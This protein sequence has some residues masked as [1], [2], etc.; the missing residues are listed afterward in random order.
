MPE[1]P[2]IEAPAAPQAPPTTPQ[3]SAPAPTAIPTTPA[4]TP[5]V[6]AGKFKSIEDL[7]KGY[8]E[9]QKH[10][11]STRP[12]PKPEMMQIE[13][14]PDAIEDADIPTLIE[15]AGLK[16]D[17][18]EGHWKEHGRLTDEQYAAIRKKAPGM[19]N[20]LINDMAEGLVA[21]TELMQVRRQQIRSECAQILGGE[22]QLKSLL[23]AASTF[24]PPDELPA[25][26]RLLADPKTAK[27]AIRVLQQMH[28]DSV[29]A[30]KSKPLIGGSTMPGGGPARSM[31]EYNALIAAVARG[32]QGARARIMATSPDDIEKW[33]NQQ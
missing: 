30:G 21:K 18:I 11:S 10:L 26:N 4:E 15:R 27:S 3:P 33:S 29:G 13:S 7:E 2:V 24:V 32:D 17:E 12:Q 20:K 14:I 8:T 5:K 23:N 31:D 1:A 25:M 22:D 6:Y 19:S 9:L 28:A 16:T